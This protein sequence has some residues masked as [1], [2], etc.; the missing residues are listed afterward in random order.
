MAQDELDSNVWKL[1][2][3]LPFTAAD[4]HTY[5]L[6]SYKYEIVSANEGTISEG[7]NERTESKL[8]RH[9]YHTFKPNYKFQRFRNATAILARDAVQFFVRKELTLFDLDMITSVQTIQRFTDIVG[10][11]AG[12][13][14]AVIEDLFEDA[15]DEAT[16]KVLN[17]IFDR[18]YYYFINLCFDKFIQ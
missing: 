11:F 2:V 8:R 16:R 12:S 9:F 18:K 3:N 15:I 17:I 13:N 14:R 7:Q 5:G 1:D 4:F 10:C 6:F